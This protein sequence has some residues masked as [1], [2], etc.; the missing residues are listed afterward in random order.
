MIMLF[1]CY[2]FIFSVISIFLQTTKKRNSSVNY[3]KFLFSCCQVCSNINTC[4]CDKNWTSSDCSELLRS[5]LGIVDHTNGPIG[6]LEKPGETGTLTTP[7]AISETVADWRNK[8][9]KSNVPYGGEHTYCF[10]INKPLIISH[11]PIYKTFYF[12]VLAINISLDHHFTSGKDHLLW[13]NSNIL[14]ILAL[15][16]YLGATL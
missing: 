13:K 2:Y 14:K 11:S 5:R 6:T 1:R 4:H 9:V 12:P 16:P 3:F 15:S 8:T 10:N 7:K